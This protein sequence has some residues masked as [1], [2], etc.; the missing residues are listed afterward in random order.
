MTDDNIFNF[1]RVWLIGQTFTPKPNQREKEGIS[2]EASP[3]VPGT[4]PKDPPQNLA[5]PFANSWC[6][7]FLGSLT[8]LKSQRTLVQN[9][10]QEDGNK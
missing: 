8:S 2:R 1:I 4:N 7:R 9:M 10:P 3:F 5:A 6:L